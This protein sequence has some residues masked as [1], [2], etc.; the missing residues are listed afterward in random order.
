[1]RKLNDINKINAVNLSRV[2][3]DAKSVY[4]GNTCDTHGQTKVSKQ[5]VS[6]K[7]TESEGVRGEDEKHTKI[8]EIRDIKQNKQEAKEEIH[9][10]IIE[11]VWEGRIRRIY[12]RTRIY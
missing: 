11:S 1:M 12:F 8:H 4:K 2:L 9:N 7:Q 6:E 10:K 5:L 3:A